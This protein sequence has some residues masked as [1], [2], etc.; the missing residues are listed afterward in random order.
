MFCILAWHHHSAEQWGFGKL[1]WSIDWLIDWLIVLYAVSAS[2]LV[3]LQYMKRMLVY[4]RRNNY[5]VR[6]KGFPCSM[7]R[8]LQQEF[9]LFTPFTAWALGCSWRRLFLIF[10]EPRWWP[11]EQL[12]GRKSAPPESLW[13][14]PRKVNRVVQHPT[15]PYT[16]SLKPFSS[17]YSW[18]HQ[19]I[20]YTV[21][22]QSKRLS[23]V[24]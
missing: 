2:Y 5:T 3:Y 15:L 18:W 11:T 23:T 13:T 21:C 12:T 20:Q 22:F 14:T 16:V 4:L 24:R 8:D 17:V 19:T 6:V 10:S 1:D 7:L 9:A